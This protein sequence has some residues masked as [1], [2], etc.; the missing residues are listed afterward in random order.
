M[1]DVLLSAE[2][3]AAGAG[4]VTVESTLSA[5]VPVLPVGFDPFARTL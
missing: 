4:F 5:P 3:S 1:L 2:E